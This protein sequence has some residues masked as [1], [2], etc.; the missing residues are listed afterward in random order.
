M[1]GAEAKRLAKKVYALARD[2][3]PSS[4]EAFQVEEARLRL[5]VRVK[6]SGACIQSSEEP[7]EMMLPH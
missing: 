3:S 1:V 6:T 5:W 2:K 4:L 7:G